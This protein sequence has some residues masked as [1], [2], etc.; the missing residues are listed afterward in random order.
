MNEKI[1]NI[2]CFYKTLGS[3]TKLMI[4]TTLITVTTLILTAIYAY[5]ATHTPMHYELLKI[6]D[7]LLEC[8]KSVATTGFIWILILSYLEK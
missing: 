4:R 2:K 5:T 6:S 1:K 3:N 7:D 8:T